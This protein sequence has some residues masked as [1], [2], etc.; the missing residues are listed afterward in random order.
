MTILHAHW[1]VFVL[2]AIPVAGTTAFANTCAIRAKPACPYTAN[3]VAAGFAAK[4]RVTFLSS[5]VAATVQGES[6]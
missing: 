6:Q 5:F 4:T 1:A 3:K 2:V